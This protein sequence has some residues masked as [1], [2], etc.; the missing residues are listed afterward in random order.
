M[1]DKQLARDLEKL[2]GF[3]GNGRSAF[4]RYVAAN[5][6]AL[7]RRN[8]GSGGP[9]WAEMA[10]FLNSRGLRNSKGEELTAIAFKRAYER[11][12]REVE[13]RPQKPLKV[14]PERV[15]APVNW[16][17]AVVS[18]G[19]FVASRTQP[20][21]ATTAP[22]GPRIYGSPL[23]PKPKTAAQVLAE[24]ALLKNPH[25]RTHEEKIAI[26]KRQQ[27]ERSGR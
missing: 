19:T 20:A 17:P 26:V 13:A 7:K 10:D 11:V 3:G 25:E 14:E 8:I 23:P 24:A 2:P 15:R 16:R 5:F 12:A 18:A 9:T 1:K 21:A 6:E 4:R 27:E 22:A